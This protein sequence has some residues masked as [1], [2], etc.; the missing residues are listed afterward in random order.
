[1]CHWRRTAEGFEVDYMKEKTWIVKVL[2][3]SADVDR[4]PGGPSNDHLF[5]KTPLDED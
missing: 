2:N 3:A 5:V 1:M 4:A